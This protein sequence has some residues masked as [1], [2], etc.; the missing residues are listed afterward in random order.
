MKST[1]PDQLSNGTSIYEVSKYEIFWRNFIAG[2]AR[3]LGNFLFTVLLFIIISIL[4]ARFVEPFVTPLVDSMN[5]IS[6][7]VSTINRA[8]P[9]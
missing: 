1:D 6:D 9:R 5:S 3:G 4:T 2:F 8:Q 7:I